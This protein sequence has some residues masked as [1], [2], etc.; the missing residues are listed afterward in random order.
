[1]VTGQ[2]DDA[3]DLK[4]YQKQVGVATVAPYR[5]TEDFKC[6]LSHCW[7]C[8]SSLCEVKMYPDNQEKLML[9]T[10]VVRYIR[11]EASCEQRRDAATIRTHQKD[12]NCERR[13]G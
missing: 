10:S 1:M 11:R 2:N 4:W 9:F 5:Q 13:S 7:P 8:L 3:D 12:V 6:E